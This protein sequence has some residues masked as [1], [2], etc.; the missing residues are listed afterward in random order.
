MP[1][2]VPSPKP[3]FE[4][5]LWSVV[6]IYGSPS[7]CLSIKSLGKPGPSSFIFINVEFLLLLKNISTFFLQNLFAFPIKFLRP[8]II[9]V[10]FV[11]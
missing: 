1:I 5:F 11:Y 7:L 4:I 8:Y 2:K 9:S 10:D 3:Y 6:L